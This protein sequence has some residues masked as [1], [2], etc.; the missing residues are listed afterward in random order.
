MTRLLFMLRHPFI[1]RRWVR[2]VNAPWPE[3]VL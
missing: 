1:S 3:M 2:A